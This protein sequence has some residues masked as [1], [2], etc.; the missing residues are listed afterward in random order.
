MFFLLV[1]VVLESKAYSESPVESFYKNYDPS[2]YNQ[3]GYD[4]LSSTQSLQSNQVGP[5]YVIGPQDIIQ[6]NVW[7]GAMADM[8]AEEEAGKKRTT[9]TTLSRLTGMGLLYFRKSAGWPSMA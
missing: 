8:N 7:G 6:I 3:F 9:M 1:S 2:G 5:D 4:V